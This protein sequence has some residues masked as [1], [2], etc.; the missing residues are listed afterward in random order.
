MWSVERWKF[1]HLTAY[2]D[3]GGMH[4]EMELVQGHIYKI[5]ALLT[6]FYS[7]FRNMWTLTNPA[8]PYTG[9]AALSLPFLRNGRPLRIWH[10]D[11]EI[12]FF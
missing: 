1:G 12:S 11:T 8:V 9:T 7:H 4:L 2:C 3:E 6:D 10:L 5:V